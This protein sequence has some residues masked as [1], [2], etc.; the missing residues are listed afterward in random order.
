MDFISRVQ[1]FDILLFGETWINRD[2]PVDLS[3]PGFECAHVFAKKNLAELKVA[4][5][6]AVFPSISKLV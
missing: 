3:I 6:A 5:L 4:D 2:D 1:N